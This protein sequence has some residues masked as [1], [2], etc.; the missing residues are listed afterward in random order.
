[1]VE[2]LFEEMTERDG[3]NLC[4]RAH[5][6]ISADWGSMRT[7]TGRPVDQS[8]K[9]DRTYFTFTNYALN[10]CIDYIKMNMKYWRS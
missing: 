6:G 8:V 2:V 10:F 7:G 1:M 3:K 9:R 4:H 5:Q